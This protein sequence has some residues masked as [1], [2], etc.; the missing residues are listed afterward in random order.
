MIHFYILVTFYTHCYTHKI[1]QEQEKPENDTENDKSNSNKQSD[2][3]TERQKLIADSLQVADVG[4]ARILCYQNKAP[5]APE[6][7]QN[8][9][10]VVYSIK[11]PISTKSG[12][13]FIPTTSDRILDAPD[14]LNDYCEYMFS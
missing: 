11:T 13:R 8:P 5:A 9:L 7:H 12:S 4:S 10:K 6:S 2:S 3:K 14:I 1:K